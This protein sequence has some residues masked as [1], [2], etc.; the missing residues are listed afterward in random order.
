M[1]K[2]TNNPTPNV[3]VPGLSAEK[4]AELRARIAEFAALTG[5][6][7]W[8][9]A[10]TTDAEL[11]QRVLDAV[12]AELREKAKQKTPPKVARPL[13]PVK[14]R[15]LEAA[16]EIKQN[17][18]AVERAFM[19]R[20]LVQCTL[21]HKDPGDVP[22]WTRTNGLLT[23]VIS[24]YRD[25]KTRKAL[26][27]YGSIPRLLMFWIVTEATQKRSRRIK[28]GSSLDAFM[29]KIGLN[30]RTGGGKRGDAQR[31]HEQMERLCRA[32]IS[33]EDDRGVRGSAWRDMQVAPDGELWWN[34]TR[35]MQD[36]LWDSWIELG[37]KFF[38]A[39]T[40]APVPVDLRALRALKRSPLALDLYA[41]MTYTAF[42][43]TKKRM[44]RTIPWEGL[45]GQMGGDYAELRDFKKKLLLALRKVQL[46]YPALRVETTSAGLVIH[47]CAPAIP[48]NV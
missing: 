35:S 29:R 48:A 8:E 5:A 4:L 36:N 12:V 19:A 25:R 45:H 39:I 9:N 27:P 23:L 21:P 30:P 41:L 31:L 24:P 15:L 22:I 47:P 28:L 37:E 3:F 20:Q 44:A 7:V 14:E 33:F 11:F 32:I 2:R 43:A 17:P 6:P 40:A 10:P 34:P 18:D 16:V 26:Y 46:A 13:S 38:A 42:S 1:A